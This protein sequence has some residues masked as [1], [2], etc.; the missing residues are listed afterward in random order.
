MSA[1]PSTAVVPF[2]ELL[3]FWSCSRRYYYAYEL[4][5]PGLAQ[6]PQAGR[7]GSWIHAQLH[8][9]YLGLP[10]AL[11]ENPDYAEQWARYQEVIAEFAQ[12]QGRSEWACHVPLGALWLTGRLDRLYIQEQALTI[13]DWKTGSAPPSAATEFQLDVYACLLY[14]ARETLGLDEIESITASA[15]NLNDRAWDLHRDYAVEQIEALLPEIAALAE[16]L[17]QSQRPEVPRPRYLK[18]RVWCTMCEY[19]PLCPEGSLHA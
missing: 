8:Q 18:E 14:L 3:S 17:V 11:S 13:L 5:V 10:C 9:A 4:K 6:D 12:A 19:Q 1:S 7:R 16:E 2:S 15:I